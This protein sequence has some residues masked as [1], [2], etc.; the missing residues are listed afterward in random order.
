MVRVSLKGGHEPSLLAI[1]DVTQRIIVMT[2]T[3]RA[4]TARLSCK[5]FG[6]YPRAGLAQRDQQGSRDGHRRKAD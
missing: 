5:Q 2:W 4:Y 1:V 6:V 3:L